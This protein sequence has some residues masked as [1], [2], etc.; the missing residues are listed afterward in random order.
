MNDRETLAA[1][2]RKAHSARQVCFRP[3]STSPDTS[4]WL[5]PVPGFAPIQGDVERRLIAER[6]VA[7]SVQDAWAG[8]IAR[9]HDSGAAVDRADRSRA[10]QGCR[11]RSSPGS[12]AA[13]RRPEASL[14]GSA[15][16]PSKPS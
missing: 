9:M 15:S 4:S 8:S 11:I 10:A 3:D 14:R 13:N 16:G 2:R 12:G 7:F 5:Y 1:C 6:D